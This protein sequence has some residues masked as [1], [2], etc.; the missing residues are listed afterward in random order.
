MYEGNYLYFRMVTERRRASREDFINYVGVWLPGFRRMSSRFLA[1]ERVGKV[2]F[3]WENDEY[4]IIKD[5]TNGRIVF[6]E[7]VR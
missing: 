5:L 1:R 3:Y 6:K 7:K 4:F 2:I